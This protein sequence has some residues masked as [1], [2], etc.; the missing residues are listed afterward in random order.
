MSASTGATERMSFTARCGTI[1]LG[2][3]PYIIGALFALIV[4]RG[5]DLPAVFNIVPLAIFAPT[6]RVAWYSLPSPR[7]RQPVTTL[8]LLTMLLFLVACS[9]LAAAGYLLTGSFQF[10]DSLLPLVSLTAFYQEEN[11]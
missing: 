2:Y 4:V 6:V 9:W 1:V 3:M 5:L 10:L 7:R 11:I 8:V